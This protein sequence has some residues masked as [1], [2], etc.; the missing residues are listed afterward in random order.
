MQWIVGH[1]LQLYLI[2]ISYDIEVQLTIY[3]RMLS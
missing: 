1:G 2:I 3:N